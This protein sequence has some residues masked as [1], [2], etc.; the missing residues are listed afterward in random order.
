[1]NAVHNIFMRWCNAG[2]NKNHAKSPFSSKC[3]QKF[4]KEIEFE[5]ADY[6][7]LMVS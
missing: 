4:L 7:L 2:Y 1:M 3:F 5:K 6:L